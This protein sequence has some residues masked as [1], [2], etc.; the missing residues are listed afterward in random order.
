VSCLYVPHEEQKCGYILIA[1]GLLIG[2]EFFRIPEFNVEAP[3]F[4][5]CP[6]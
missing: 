1:D 6:L 5:G 2:F 4:A 3:R